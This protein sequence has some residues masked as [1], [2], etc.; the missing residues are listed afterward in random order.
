MH[1]IV[2][3]AGW[4]TCLIACIGA[5]PAQQQAPQPTQQQAPQADYHGQ[6]VFNGL[7]VPGAVVT[8][9]EGAQKTVVVTDTQG[10]YVF[11]ALPQGAATL[12]VELT[13][14]ARIHQDIAIKGRRRTRA[15]RAEARN[16]RRDSCAG[17]DAACRRHRRTAPHSASREVAGQG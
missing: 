1:A 14:F 11:T 10:L 5:A 12:D 2:R 13:G 4:M 6:V 8:L 17:Q 9:T 16:A 3:T 7:P 15:H